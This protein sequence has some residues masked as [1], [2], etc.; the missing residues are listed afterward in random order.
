[1][2]KLA[3]LIVVFIACLATANIAT[4]NSVDYYATSDP[5][6]TP[7]GM[8][9]WVKISGG[10]PIPWPGA[11]GGKIWFG[12]ANL[13]VHTNVKVATHK[14]TGP[15]APK[16]GATAVKT[17]C[18]APPPPGTTK[19]AAIT[20]AVQTPAGGG[21]VPP[22]MF[23]VTVTLIPQ[24]DWHTIEFTRIAV[25]DGAEE[26]QGPTTTIAQDTMCFNCDNAP[27]N[28]FELRDG[29]FGV[30]PQ[31][32]N[33]TEVWI[34]PDGD[35]VN[36]SPSAHSF[37]TGDNGTW[38]ASIVSTD[39]DGGMRADGGVRWNRS[40]PPG[41][42]IAAETFN[43]STALTSNKEGRFDVYARDTVR[44]GYVYFRIEGVPCVPAMSTWGLVLM[45]GSL[46]SL[47]FG[48]LWLR[49]RGT[50]TA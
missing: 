32:M 44:N 40:G 18:V 25:F 2:R 34:F 10:G 6:S 35:V 19:V 15:L 47:A 5:G 4:A 13:K 21:G 16:F 3:F 48:V 38:T 50:A 41:G 11:V 36:P 12:K 29:Y 46:T 20:S 33:I 45:A 49:K 23:T 43:M 9:P 14:I 37:M 26:A 42:L 8:S 28:I 1:M 31:N 7:L 39:P 30:V 24:P 22:A 27:A 17:F